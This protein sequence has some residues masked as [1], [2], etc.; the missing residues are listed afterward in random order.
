MSKTL[1]AK[2]IGHINSDGWGE[3]SPWSGTKFDASALHVNRLVRDLSHPEWAKLFTTTDAVALKCAEWN[4]SSYTNGIKVDGKMFSQVSSRV[5]LVSAVSEIVLR[6]ASV[7]EHIIEELLSD[8]LG[9]AHASTI[10][11]VLNGELPENFDSSKAREWAKTR[12]PFIESCTARSQ[13]IHI[14]LTGSELARLEE[15][16][17]STKI[18]MYC[19]H[20]AKDIKTFG[21][22]H[23]SLLQAWCVSCWFEHTSR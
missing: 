12:L 13:A 5:V 23:I 10:D 17:K 20:L 18:D 15:Q 6:G 22:G 14:G 2:L 3:G 1:R 21:E 8:I 16:E 9:G 7:Q 4:Y 19:N 11:T